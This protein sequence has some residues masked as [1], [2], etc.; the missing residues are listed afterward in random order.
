MLAWTQTY[1]SNPPFDDVNVSMH[2]AGD[3]LCADIP[4]DRDRPLED[5]HRREKCKNT[6][7]DACY[8]VPVEVRHRGIPVPNRL[9]VRGGSQ[10]HRQCTHPQC[11]GSVREPPRSTA[12]STLP[13]RFSME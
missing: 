5:I 2:T 12:L 13:E 4:R 10:R 6:P 3:L 8:S 9:R 1:V 11:H 7:G